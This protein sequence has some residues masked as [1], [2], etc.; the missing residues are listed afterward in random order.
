[1]DRQPARVN[2]SEFAA[3]TKIRENADGTRDLKVRIVCSAGTYIRVL[4]ENLAQKL[5]TSAHLAELRRTRA[6]RF[7]IADAIT[8]N[9]LA[10][11]TSSALADLLISAND[12][13]SQLASIEVDQEQKKRIRHGIDVAVADDESRFFN[14]GDPVRLASKGELIAVG[15]YD[16]Q[17]CLIHP[18]VVIAAE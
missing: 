18:R 5:G 13:I 7:L 15:E 4:A 16:S 3:V 11:S 1:M 8:L 14:H 6:G 17:R 2:V 10:E 12:A 9:G